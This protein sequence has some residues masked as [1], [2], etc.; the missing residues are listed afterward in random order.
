[1]PLDGK[2]QTSR[3]L[4]CHLKML[5]LDFGGQAKYTGGFAISHGYIDGDNGLDVSL[6]PDERL[7]GMFG[8]EDGLITQ[9]GFNSTKKLLY[10]P[11]GQDR[12]T[13][14]SF[15]G[16]FLTGF[17][18]RESFGRLSGLGAWATSLAPPP[19]SPPP[20]SPPPD[21]P[22]FT[23]CTGAARRAAAHALSSKC[24][25]RGTNVGTLLARM[26]CTILMRNKPKHLMNKSI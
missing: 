11:W 14:F 8:K 2:L 3:N 26:R 15:S 22:I 16:G 23:P 20:P 17:F 6:D 25:Q 10:G 4:L 5:I 21:S 7:T 9:I 18:G 12:G 24:L 1:V 13:P 19:P